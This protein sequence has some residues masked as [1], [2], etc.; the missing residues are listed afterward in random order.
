MAI[1]TGLK[2]QVV[3][4][5]G[6]AN[7]IGKATAQAFCAQG[8]R[9]VLLDIDQKSLDAAKTAFEQQHFE[10]D[11]FALDVADEQ[12]VQEVFASIHQKYGRI[13]VLVNNAGILRDRSL[14]KMSFEEWDAVINVNLKGVFNCG[15]IAAG[16]MVAQGKGVILNAS[17]VVGLYGN[18][19]QSNYVATKSGVIGM[20]KVWARELG[21][22]GV[23]VNAVAPGFISTDILKD[24]PE[25]IL[26][27]LA[28]KAPLKR[29]GTPEDVANAYVYLASDQASFVTGT[30]LSVDGGVVT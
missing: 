30:T 8:A 26:Q 3:L 21:S 23:R 24:M 16:Y 14:L 12:A 22:K 29:L 5:T 25:E 28:G 19:G 15:K 9:C 2:N 10:V 11:I 4:I 18:Y 20:T 7:G 6:G 13:D 17:S 27:K 1:D